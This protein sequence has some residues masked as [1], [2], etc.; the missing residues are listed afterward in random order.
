M[1]N[2]IRIFLV[3]LFIP[4]VLIVYDYFWRKDTVERA[5]FAIS[6]GVE[7]GTVINTYS[8]TYKVKHGYNDRYFV[9]VKY[10]DRTEVVGVSPATWID[11]KEGES[12]CFEKTQLLPHLYIVSLIL[13]MIFVSIVCI[14]ILVSYILEPFFTWLFKK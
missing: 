8:E 14:V 10:A 2:R 7:C 9:K 5:P 1:N 13:S 3:I 11:T 6:K 4:S 12:I